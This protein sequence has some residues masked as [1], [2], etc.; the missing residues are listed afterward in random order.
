MHDIAGQ[1]TSYREE[2]K[3]S[4]H[5]RL[6]FTIWLQ[7]LLNTHTHMHDFADQLMSY[8]E[9][10][11]CS[12]HVG[13]SF[14]MLTAATFTNPHPT[15]TTLQVNSCI[16]KTNEKREGT[17]S[18]CEWLSFEMCDKKDLL[19]TVLFYPWRILSIKVFA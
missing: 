2:R 12:L 15:H 16:F 3:C 19:M 1:V 10:R 14:T 7:W 11:K 17:L 8:K 5:E 9:E 6:G 18:L 13:H 4:L